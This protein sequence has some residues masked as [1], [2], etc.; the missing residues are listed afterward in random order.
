MGKD[1]LL[2]KLGERIALLRKS[3]GYRQIDLADKVE[4]EEFAVRRIEIGGTN[5]TVKTLA[6]IAKA[7]EVEIKDLFDFK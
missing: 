1:E 7:L 6:K 2:N 4:M 5:P 3:K